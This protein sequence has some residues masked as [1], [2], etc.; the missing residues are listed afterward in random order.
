MSRF[1]LYLFETGLCLSLLYLVYVFFLRKETFFRFNRLYLLSSMGIS[2]LIP[3]V[4]F[5]FITP[6]PEPFEQPFRE[7]GRIRALYAGFILSTDTDFS[8]PRYRSYAAAE[9][10]NMGWQQSGNADG[11]AQTGISASSQDSHN[12]G[13]VTKLNM[14]INPAR[15]LML[16]YLAGVFFFLVRFIILLVWLQHTIRKNKKVDYGDFNLV[17][18]KKDV[19]PFS[20][21]RYVFINR[22][23]IDLPG[24]RQ[25]LA[26][27]RVH[28][29]QHHSLDLLLAHG[30]SIM[31][32]FNP[33]VWHLQKAIKITHEY[34]ADSRVIKQGYALEDYQS[35]LLSQLISIRSVALVNNFNLLSIK[36]RITMMT[37][38][39]SGFSARLKILITI[40]AA[41][42]LFFLFAHMTVESPAY[43]FTNF[44][45][46]KVSKLDGIWQNT[47]ADSYGYLIHFHNNTLSILESGN[48]VS[49][50]EIPVSVT[51]NS[52]TLTG[53]GE[54]QSAMRYELHDD[55]LKIWWNTEEW[56]EYRK[57]KYKNSF[58]ALSPQNMRN[59]VLPVIT[60]TRILERQDMVFSIYITND[61]YNVDGEDSSEAALREVIAK[62]LGKF[63]IINRPYVTAR[64]VADKGVKMERIYHLQQ[65]LRN[66]EIYKVGYASRPVHQISPLQY[67]AAAMPLKLPPLDAIMLDKQETIDRI[68][69]YTAGA[70][71]DETRENMKRFITLHPDY[72][73]I[74]NWDNETTYEEY[75]NG[76]DLAFNVVY[77]FRDTFS[78]EKYGITYAE[79]PKNLQ[80]EVRE[81]YPMRLTQINRDEDV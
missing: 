23:L 19:T 57:T 4:H 26:H 28:V 65:V 54:G 13:S 48:D 37:K 24:F 39:K 55:H 70:N 36:K 60:N 20:F 8:D 62:R 80:L 1:L 22:E 40:P 15:A 53:D 7:I 21:F 43:I 9:F 56:S 3:L 50:L 35:L 44:T 10:E 32:W 38:N 51:K 71:T 58:E 72:I 75:L 6:N 27:E 14:L 74:Y 31:Q 33:F 17:P 18:M 76:I 29:K 2:V 41:I 11:V 73:A 64:L 5:S 79:L 49:V 16:I 81:K 45:K 59:A 69:E 78:M 67:H 77:E 12:A 34:L 63:K 47:H 61:K 46:G 25:V 42:A 52:F 30:I 66:L 68:I